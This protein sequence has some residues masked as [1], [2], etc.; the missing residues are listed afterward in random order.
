MVAI[1]LGTSDTYFGTMSDCR[2]DPNGEGHVFGSPTGDYMTLICFKN[3]SLAREQICKDFNLDWAGFSAYLQSTPPGNDGKMMLPWFE[4]EIVPRVLQ[5]GLHR[6]DLEIDDAAGH[7]RAVVEAQMMSMR[8]HAQWMNIQAKEIYATGGAS[9]NR[10]I[11]QI[12]ANVHNCPVSPFES[13]NGASLG[14]ALR[15]AQAWLSD[16]G[17]APDWQDTVGPFTQP[18]AG[19]RIDPQPEAVAVYDA[20]IQEYAAFEQRVLGTLA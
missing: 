6:K 3:G 13:T 19:S 4:P 8:L 11:L 17:D 10:D 5:P 9:A 7:C 16:E 14:A 18:V 2:T 15:A 12:M 1:S 20:L